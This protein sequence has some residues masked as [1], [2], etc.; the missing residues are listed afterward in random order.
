M[1]RAVLLLAAGTV[2]SACGMFKRGGAPPAHRE[3]TSTSIYG[4]WVLNSPVDSTAFAGATS[5][6][7]N[8]S[9]T[10]F[11]ILASYP[12]Q[13]DSRVTGT[14]SSS[15]GG[16]I[17]LTPMTGGTSATYTGRS[18]ALVPGQPISLIAS[19]AGGSLVFK[20]PHE[21]DPTPS[22]SW[23][24]RENAEAAGLIR[25]DAPKP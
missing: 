25:K 21:T 20:P 18:M 6:Q 4:R 7:M 23:M 12:G 16:V 22:S 11:T 10:A 5:V 1:R 24:K 13:P 9:E 15:E 19:A 17:I 8:L 2:L 14:V 3:P